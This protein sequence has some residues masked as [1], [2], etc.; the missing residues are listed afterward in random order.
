MYLYLIKR[1]SYYTFSLFIR[2]IA[3]S[4][5]LLIVL[6]FDCKIN[7]WYFFKFIYIVWICSFFNKFYTI[8]FLLR[9]IEILHSK[10]ERCIWWAS[11]G[12]LLKGRISLLFFNFIFTF[13]IHGFSMY[14]LCSKF[15]QFFGTLLVLFNILSI[16]KKLPVEVQSIVILLKGCFRYKYQSFFLVWINTSSFIKTDA[17]SELCSRIFMCFL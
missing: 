6:Q 13:F 11:I 3:F 4:L 10:V 1:F 12:R 7:P 16:H 2:N 17:Y 14:C 9:I 5:H 8:L 15:K